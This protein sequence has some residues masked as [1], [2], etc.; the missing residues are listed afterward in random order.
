MKTNRSARRGIGVEE[1]HG[2]NKVEL[3]IAHWFTLVLEGRLN[4]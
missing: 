2:E 4:A 3:K 1:R